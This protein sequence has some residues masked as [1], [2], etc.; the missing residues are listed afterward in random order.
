VLS[1]GEAAC[2]T[3]RCYSRDMR[4]ALEHVTRGLETYARRKQRP[5][6]QRAGT[7]TSEL[8]FSSGMIEA[9]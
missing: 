4:N 5:V 2:P 8:A 3:R 7:A 1:P 9:S 6:G